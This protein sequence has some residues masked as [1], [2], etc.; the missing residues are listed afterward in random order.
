[1]IL[2]YSNLNPRVVELA[3]L[4]EENKEKGVKSTL[5]TL[6]PTF[7]M[8][9]NTLY[10]TTTDHYSANFYEE[11]ESSFDIIKKQQGSCFPEKSI[12]DKLELLRTQLIDDYHRFL[13]NDI[14]A[15][16]VSNYIGMNCLSVFNYNPNIKEIFSTE[17]KD[18]LIMLLKSKIQVYDYFLNL[19][20]ESKEL[21]TALKLYPNIPKGI[22]LS[23]MNTYI[24]YRK[25][26]SSADEKIILKK[27][28]QI[29]EQ[30]SNWELYR[31]TQKSFMQDFAVQTIG[32]DKIETQIPK[33]ITTTKLN[34]Y[35]SYFNYLLMDYNIVQLPKIVLEQQRFKK[36]TP[37]EFSI[38]S[39]FDEKYKKEV[40]LIKKLP[41][42]E[43]EK[44]FL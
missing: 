37:K 30:E 22:N 31:I 1:M 19:L 25:S 32:I 13:N 6:R 28:I 23:E 4:T 39:H 40:E 12:K 15:R 16:D 3:K 44:Y 9:D 21:T 33:T 38:I 5:L 41:L 17:C 27:L 2:P 7:I 43:R 18:I 29:L 20:S 10:Y 8:P 36:I 14:S 35:E 26:T 34:P 42:K 11:V 24:E